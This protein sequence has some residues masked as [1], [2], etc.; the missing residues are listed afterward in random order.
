MKKRL[1][2][3][4]ILLIILSAVGTLICSLP[5]KKYFIH[6]LVFATHIFSFELIFINKALTTILCFMLIFI[7]FRLFKRLTTAWLM[8]IIF[9]SASI[10][11][12]ILRLQCFFR[13]LI[14]IELIIIIVLLVNK[15]EFK[16]KS[17]PISLKLGILMAFISI[18]FI[19]LNT[20]ASFFFL[21]HYYKNISGIYDAIIS[22]LKYIFYMDKS[23]IQPRTKGAH[24]FADAT[25]TINWLLIISSFLFILK[26][27][28]YNPVI[29]AIDHNKIKQY[30][31]KY[32]INPISYL[33]IDSDKSY[34]FGK[35]VDGA[36]AY[37]VCGDVAICCAD[38]LCNENEAGLFIA[39]FTNFCKDNN[40][41]ICF[42]QV[43]AKYIEQFRLLDFGVTKYGEEAMFNLETYSLHGK[44]TA[45]LRQ[46]LNKATREHFHTFE[47]CPNLNRDL[48]IEHQIKSVSDE[49][50][51]FKKSHEM[52]F[53]LGGLALENPIERRYFIATDSDDTILG[54]IIFVP[55]LSG[56]GYYADVTRRRKDAPIGVMESIVINAF[57]KMKDEGVK[58][59]SLGLVPLLNTASEYNSSNVIPK[60]MEFAYEN[61][62]MLYGFKTLYQYK[63]KY[64][65]TD[66]QPRYLAYYP[67][68]FTAKIA[69]SVAK[70]QNPDGAK[71]F[72]L[73]KIKGYY[74][75]KKTIR[76][77]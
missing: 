37:K 27:L 11:N 13:P 52:S 44:S 55:F 66:W 76:K 8:S 65:P 38:P 21:K 50:L 33:S 17:D 71:G 25:L 12:N 31:N 19:L 75:N 41:D 35:N 42:C 51:S 69:Y 1:I 9:L 54:F 16:K 60:I 43:T 40:W 2:D 56:L 63:K 6:H 73:S 28:I 70:I 45:K 22:I 67:K 5:T 77:D 48:N 59:G 74:T 72:I 61:L 64:A 7:S 29:S 68:T 32:S 26:P 47:Y 46:A 20:I 15:S 36:I 58:W 34:Y 30:L 53:M 57:N 18:A 39:E 49:W 62:N 14:L 24:I 3:F 4:C 10:I 23:F